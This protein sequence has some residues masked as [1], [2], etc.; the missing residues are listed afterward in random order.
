VGRPSPKGRATGVLAVDCGRFCF[1]E[2]LDEHVDEF[3]FHEH[4]VRTGFSDSTVQLG[5]F[6][7][8]QRDHAHARVIAA[9]PCDGSDAVHERHVEVDDDRIGLELLGELDRG[10]PV[11]GAADDREFRL[12]LD[13]GDE[14]VDEWAVVVGEQHVDGAAARLRLVHQLGS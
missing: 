11:A 7:A 12:P 9:K 13:Q 8:R 14:R 10:E 2:A 6:V 5:L 1:G 3:R 4:R